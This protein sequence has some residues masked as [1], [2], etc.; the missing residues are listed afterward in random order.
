MAKSF[1]LLAL[2]SVVS[3]PWASA[4][5]S[6]DFTARATTTGDATPSVNGFMNSA[7]DAAIAEAN[8]SG[9]PCQ[10]PLSYAPAIPPIY[11]IVRQHINTNPISAVETFVADDMNPSLRI[12]T[13]L[14]DSI[15]SSG[16]FSNGPVLFG[17][18]MAPSL[19]I[20]PHIIGSDKLGH[21][22]SQGYDYFER[23]YAGNS[24]GE[25]LDYG[26]ALENGLY[27]MAT[28]GVR[29]Y[30]DLSANEAGLRFYSELTFGSNPYITCNDG[31]WTR[32]R[33]FNISSYVTAA[34]DE[35]V[36]CSE[37]NDGLG[38]VVATSLAAR[39]MTCPV[40]L[41]QCRA[42]ALSTC[43]SRLV[44]PLC[45]AAAGVAPSATLSC[46][47][48]SAA[49]PAVPT[50]SGGACPTPSRSGNGFMDTATSY[51]MELYEEY[52]E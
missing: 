37:F 5:E 50:A 8:G 36:N 45:L 26:M 33:G 13:S 2:A 21:F 34:W 7:L 24:V 16:S 35:A 20:G 38:A 10:D 46:V 41:N 18:G 32:A 42:I 15:Y 6:D 27:G 22:A 44:S 23:V 11:E 4:Y 47:E 12:T 48:R 29:S 19:R 1:L 9:S 3:A 28:T 30:G 43:S 39:G 51:I 17:V 52:I 14:G 31:R 49:L 25:A 40:D